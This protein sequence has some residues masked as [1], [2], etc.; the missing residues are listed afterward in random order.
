MRGYSA[1]SIPAKSAY[2][3]ANLG[4]DVLAL[5]AALGYP[6]AAAVV[7]HDWG[8]L[9]A[10]AAALGDPTRI[11][12][13]ATLAVPYATF[14]NYLLRD[15]D[16]QRRSWYMY[17]FSTPMAISVFRRDDYAFVDRLWREWSPGL[18]PEFSLAVKETLRVSGVDEAA[19][20]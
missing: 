12:R 1:G 11:E 7:G 19:L 17:F 4:M 18:D 5:I 15:G 13:L 14:G 8:A 9:A 2:F 10:Y 20:S 16:Q 6:S 3:A